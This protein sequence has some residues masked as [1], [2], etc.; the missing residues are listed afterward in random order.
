MDEVLGTGTLATVAP[1]RPLGL[2]QLTELMERTSGQPEVVLGLVDGPVA[3]EHPDLATD[4]I[5]EIPGRLPGRCTQST[6]T[7]C[8]HGTFIAG[9]LLGRRGSASPAICPGCTLLLCPIFAE[10]PQ[11]DALVPSAS[12]AEVARAV[13]ALVD[14]GTRIINLSAAL[15]YPSHKGGRELGEAFDEAARRGVIVVAAAGNQGSVGSSV[16]TRHPWVLPVAACDLTGRPLEYSNLGSS[17]GRR[18][19]SAPGVGITSLAAEG[20]PHELG[21]TSVAAPLVSGAIALL[22]SEF[23]ELT[24]AEIRHIVSLAGLSRRRAI[25]P[26]LFN[27]WR[28]YQRL[29]T[30]HPKVAAP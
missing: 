26:P 16:I 1:S 3:S 29:L 30:S 21:G 11:G 23:P 4:H 22:W 28:A 19:L 2:V 25:V 10:S 24:A 12:P 18:G 17:I 15:D 5:R 27:A 6:S 14:A 13:I 9:M 8:L 7:A 20:E